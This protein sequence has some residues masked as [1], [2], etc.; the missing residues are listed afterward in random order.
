MVTRK[1][2]SL[3][4]DD[5]AEDSRHFG[6]MISTSGIDGILRNLLYRWGNL[7]P[8]RFISSVKLTVVGLLLLFGLVLAGTLYQVDHGLYAAQQL[9]FHSWFVMLGPVP[10][11]GAQLLFWVL[12]LNL[13]AGLFFRV[14]LIWTNLGLVVIHVGLILLLLG[15]LQTHYGSQYTVL[16]LAVGEESDVSVDPLTWE[17]YLAHDNELF[18]VDIRDLKVGSK[19]TTPFEDLIFVVDEIHDNSRPRSNENLDI[20]AIEAAEKLEDEELNIPGIVL[21]V[22]SS[23][24]DERPVLLY[25]GEPSLIEI[26]LG[27]DSFT[28]RLAR[29]FYALPAR[30]ELLTFESEFYPDSNVPKSFESRVLV[31]RQN[32][33]REALISMNRPM[34]LR[35]YTF[36]QTSY[37]TDDFGRDISV[38][39]VVRNPGRLIPYISSL[40]VFAGLLMHVF[41]RRGGERG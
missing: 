32:L 17:I 40:M 24:G 22:V 16:G 11:P 23:G 12:G 6:G 13:L 27:F 1:T 34:R 10:L 30:I 2:E 18:A 37:G 41:F 35:G 31:T 8:V 4:V 3:Y 14:R 20:I 5:R 28:I 7:P 25:G 19:M 26:G 33:E 39:A 29:K 9:F 36:Y 38:F 21:R 15:G